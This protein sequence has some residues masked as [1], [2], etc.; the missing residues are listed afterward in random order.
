MYTHIEREENKHCYFYLSGPYK[1]TVLAGQVG[2]S[3]EHCHATKNFL[4]D[5]QQ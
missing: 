4:S 5:H 1:S 2:V 3:L